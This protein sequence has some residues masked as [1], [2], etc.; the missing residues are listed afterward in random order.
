MAFAAMARDEARFRRLDYPTE[1]RGSG[2]LAQPIDGGVHDVGNRR[3]T[4]G[5]DQHVKVDEAMTFAL[6]VVGHPSAQRQLVAYAR[7]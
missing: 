3:C 5:D 6:V 4:I 1:L 7:R 2:K